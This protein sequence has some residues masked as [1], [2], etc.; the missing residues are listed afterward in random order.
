MPLADADIRDLV[1]GTLQ[2]LGRLKFQQIAQSLQNYEVMGR[3]LRDNRVLFEP[4]GYGIKRTIMIDQSGAARMVGL[5]EP[6]VVNVGD[7]LTTI[8]IPWR[9][10]TTNYAYERRELLENR[11]ESRI[12]DLMKVRRTDA[13][14]GLTELMEDQSWDKPLDSSNKLD[15]FGFP[16]W[17]VWNTTIGHTG[18]NPA[19]FS[20]GPGNLNAST[21]AR[22]RNY[23]GSWPTAIA[24][25]GTMAQDNISMLRTAYRKTGFKSPV[26]VPD[27]RMGAG[28]QYRLYCGEVV[29]SNIENY[30]ESQNLNL[31]RDVAAMDGV[32]TFRKNPIIWVPWLDANQLPKGETQGGTNRLY[33]I[34]WGYFYPVFLQ[35]DYLRETEPDKSPTQHNTW[36][37]HVDLTWN[38]LCVDRRRQAVF[39]TA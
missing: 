3:M 8:D 35:G 13:M 18:L 5:H 9:H 28:D 23:S 14:L 37:V 20:S 6:D 34:N 2:R 39:A 21:N 12:V 26:D 33:M 25:N 38:I 7:V 22:W 11:G 19:G 27:F 36:V 10:T 17:V 4:D 1:T 32:T 16:Y 29:L 30:A 24:A 31:G 15:V